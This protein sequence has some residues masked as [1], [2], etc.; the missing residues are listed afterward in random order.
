MNHEIRESRS[1]DHAPLAADDRLFE[2]AGTEPAWIWVSTCPTPNCEC[3]DALVLASRDGRAALLERVVVA[4][5][6]LKSSEGLSVAAAECAGLIAF[7]LDIDSTE[8]FTPDDKQPLSLTDHPRIADIASRIDGDLLESIGRLWYRGKGSADPE[9]EALLPGPL[10]LKGWKRGELLPWD[11]VCTGLREDLY[12]VDDQIYRASE[13]YCPMTSCDCEQVL[14]QFEALGHRAALSPGQVM[15]Q[16][17]GAAKLEPNP[18]GRGRL[19][20]LWAGFQQRHPG[21][22]ARFARRYADMKNIGAR[23][24]VPSPAASTKFGRNELC[25]CGSGKKFKK[26]CGAN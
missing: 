1:T 18:N 15:V 11:E 22:V 2:L 5:E 13:L 20:Q 19:A 16:L 10:K 26:C 17:S 24:E 8:V 12:I 9:Q 25:R 4:Q 21:R 3:R 6:A 7:S 14:V 23:L